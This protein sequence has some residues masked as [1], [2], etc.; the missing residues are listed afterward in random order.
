M[1]LLSRADIE[2]IAARVHEKHEDI[3]APK[4]QLC[5]MANPEALA[6]AMGYTVDYQY[7]SPDGLTLGLTSIEQTWIYVYDAKGNQVLYFLDGKTVLIDPRLQNN[8]A[9]IG[10]MNFTLAHELAHQILTR[11][12]PEAYPVQDHRICHYRKADE[13]RLVTKDWREW[14]ADALAAAL[15]LPR[16][17]IEDAMQLFNLGDRMAVL[18]KKY[19]E[20]KYNSFCTMAEYM[21]VSRTALAYRM[22]QLGLLE[23]NLL[24]QEAQARKGVPA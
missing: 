10:R 3:I 13:K 9:N 23:R 20:N 22:E 12:Y 16:E 11:L 7:L 21:Q 17:A 18:S 8:P 5:Y 1:A 19:S 14:Q 15:L 24:V 4:G 2:N 6:K